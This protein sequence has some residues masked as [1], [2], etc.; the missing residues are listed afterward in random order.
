MKA[1]SMV[2]AISLLLLVFGGAVGSVPT[3]A[4]GQRSLTI[5]GASSSQTLPPLRNIAAIAAGEAHSCALTVGGGVKCWGRNRNGQLG[6]GTTEDRSTPVDVVGLTGG[7]EA[8]AVGQSH[9]C[10]LMTEGGVKCWGA[11]YSGQLGDGTTEN[12]NTPADV[13]GLTGEVEAMT[14]GGSHTCALMVGGG[15]KCW[16]RNRNGQL[17][18]G[19]T[20]NRN[21]P[22]AVV[23][24]ASGVVAIA[25]GGLHTCALT[26]GGGVKCWGWNGFGQLGDGTTEDRSTPVAVVGLESGVAVIA[27]GATFY[28]T[29]TCALTTGARIKCWGFNSHG[30]LG[31]G[32]TRRRSTPVDV[33]DWLRLYVPFI[34]K[35]W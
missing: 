21:T 17:G 9:T 29:H 12:R 31:D 6:D 22:V 10:A 4:A 34:L 19:T 35:N 18:D 25:G 30:Q 1:R 33:L 13:V 16:G 23:G 27:A 26:V 8:I 28:G 20:E 7:V 32:T 3:T 5:R 14:A 2:L 11:N 15:V 24:L